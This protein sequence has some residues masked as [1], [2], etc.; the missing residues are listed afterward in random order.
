MPSIDGIVSGL[1]TTAL[2]NG[3]LEVAAVPKV[4]MQDQLEEYQT[5]LEAV[6]GVANRMNDLVSA[7]E[8]MD[9]EEEFSSFT[10]TIAEEGYY[11]VETDSDANP[12]T[13]DI[14]VTQLADSEVEVSQAFS[15]ASSTGVI[16]EGTFSI[17]YA[18]V[19][20]DIT[21]DGTNSS[22]SALAAEID[23]I[24]GLTAYVMNT[25]DDTNPYTLVI[26][27]DDTGSD[28]SI[29]IDTSGLGGGGTVPSFTENSTAADAMMIVN[30]VTVSSDTNSFTDVVPGVDVTVSALTAGEVTTTIAA[31][32]ATIEEKV[33]SF[34]DAYNDIINYYNTN[35]SYNPDEGIRGGLV[36]EASARDAVSGLGDVI[37]D[38]YSGLDGIFTALSQVGIST[39]SDG[40]LSLDSTEFQDA[41]DEDFDAVVDLFTH[42]DS[43]TDTYGPLATLRDKINDL[44]VDSDTGTLTSR[45]DS[46]EDSI[47][48]YEE[49]IEA[50]DEYLV[51]YEERLRQQFTYM[52]TVLAELYAAQDQLAAIFSTMSTGNDK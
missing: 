24:D 19:S 52:E 17:T 29:E 41:L 28:N 10:A 15:D 27:G 36:G 13:Y 49:R 21:I 12:G 43:D 35:S 30:G 46:L 51:N 3:I 44:Y 22:L 14:E 48:E 8:E 42:D 20:T 6:S 18:G 2:I 38:N 40:T 50:F 4:V 31:D 37:S 47:T 45:K 16:A 32:T 7:I 39:N 34:I 23:D 11:T 33:Q 1:D 5:R 25:G 9:T 26:Q